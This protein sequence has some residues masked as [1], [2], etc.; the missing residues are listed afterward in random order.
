MECVSR[1]NQ[2][3]QGVDALKD[4]IICDFIKFIKCLNRGKPFDYQFILE[5]IS[6]VEL[7]N[8]ISEIDYLIQYYLNAHD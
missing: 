5:E 7:Y 1:Q 4:K 6:L 8:D 2:K 3:V